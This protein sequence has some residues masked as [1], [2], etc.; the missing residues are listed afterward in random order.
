MSNKYVT[1]SCIPHHPPYICIGVETKYV[2]KEG[3]EGTTPHI[4]TNNETTARVKNHAYI[5]MPCPHVHMSTDANTN[6]EA[7][8][9]Y[10]KTE[11]RS[12]RNMV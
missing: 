4:K 7:H 11:T 6:T 10:M 1:S 8:A 5:H 12:R 9:R 2:A 3:A